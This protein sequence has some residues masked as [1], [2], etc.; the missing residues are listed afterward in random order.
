MTTDGVSIPWEMAVSIVSYTSIGANNTF[1][2][3]TMISGRELFSQILPRDFSYTKKMK[4]EILHFKYLM[5]KLLLE[6]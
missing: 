1:S 4:T 2:K 5:D 6:R 3:G